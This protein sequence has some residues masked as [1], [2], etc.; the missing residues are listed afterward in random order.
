MFILYLHSEQ[1]F[2]CLIAGMKLCHWR[3]ASKA[4]C[5]GR[6]V[7]ARARRSSARCQGLKGAASFVPH[8]SCLSSSYNRAPHFILPLRIRSKLPV[9]QQ[10]ASQIFFCTIPVYS[11]RALNFVSEAM[12]CGITHITRNETVLKSIKLNLKTS[13]RV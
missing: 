7:L 1:M 9:A 10:K 12:P 4:R 2:D 8:P 11:L 5:G 13:V 3:F 6:S